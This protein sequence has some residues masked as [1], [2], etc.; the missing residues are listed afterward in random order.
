MLPAEKTGLLQ[1]FLGSLPADIARRLARAVELD[2]LMESAALPH[3]AIL[4]GLRPVLRQTGQPV[5]TPTPLRLFCRPFEDILSSAPRRTKQKASLSRSS[6]AVVWQ[7]VSRTLIPGPAQSFIT[8]VKK[9]LLAQTSSDAMARTAEFWTL[10]GN[11]IRAALADDAGRKAARAALDGDVV[12][13]DAEEIALLLLAGS[14]VLKIQAV[15]PKPMAHLNEDTLWQ[16][17]AI[18]DDLIARNA[19]AAPY[20][21]VIA[22]NRL[23]RPWEALKLPLQICRQSQDTLI[24]Q[25]D[26]GLVGEILL[27]RMDNLQ[28]AILATR[29]PMPDVDALLEQ[30][31]SFAEMSAAIVKEI[32]VRRDGEWGQRLLKDRAAVGNVMDGLLE[33]APK[34]LTHALPLQKSSGPKFADFSR[35]L[36]AEKKAV[37]WRYVKLVTGC[38]NFAAAA[39]CAAKQKTSTEEMSNYLR[40][41]NEDLVKELRGTDPNRRAAAESQFEFCAELTARLFSE[42]EAELLRR[43]ARAAQSAAA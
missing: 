24:S 19:D 8:D 26:M 22:M 15:L 33:R 9:L 38:R 40:R 25:T 20:V 43:R 30:V 29:H 37:A 28:A 7:W 23:V 36:D 27:G 17:R 42:E 2:R 5:R 12:V 10:A 6:V 31:A 32:E 39:S 18:Y 3:E 4:A 13:A 14:D 21:A 16:L 1:S 35:P 11:A 41:H 34:E